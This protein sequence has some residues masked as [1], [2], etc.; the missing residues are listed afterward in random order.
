MASMVNDSVEKDYVDLEILEN[1]LE[2]WF[3]GED[4]EI[5]VRK[6]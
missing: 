2:E 5:E 4:Y 6:M 1:K 3:P